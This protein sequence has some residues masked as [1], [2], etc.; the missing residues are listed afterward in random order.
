MKTPK[1]FVLDFWGVGEVV[2]NIFIVLPT[3]HVLCQSFDVIL[4][5]AFHQ[6]A[7]PAIPTLWIKKLRLAS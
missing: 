6:V 7:I 5:K 2:A 3:C 4:R 1:Y